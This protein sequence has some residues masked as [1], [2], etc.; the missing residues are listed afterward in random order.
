MKFKSEGQGIK[1]LL[2]LKPGESITGVFKGDPVDYQQHWVGGRGVICEGA[3]CPY[4][5]EKDEEGKPLKPGFR[6]RINFLTLENSQWTAKVFEQGYTVYKN[7]RS[8][9]ESDYN[10]EKT[11][12]KITRYGSD[13]TTT[14]QIVPLP[15]HEV[16]PELEKR[17]K[18]IKLN[19]LEIGQRE[20]GE[21][22]SE[23]EDDIPA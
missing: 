17:F 18:T 4:C 6:F 23:S 11:L 15:K 14:Y 7:L 3:A 10:L 19:E 12:V 22:S 21:D 9:H 16:S 20:P 1:N 2:K 5:Q 8:L 13:K